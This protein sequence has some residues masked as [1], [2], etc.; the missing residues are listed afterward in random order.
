MKKLTTKTL[1]FIVISALLASLFCVFAYADEL[2]E[3]LPIIGVTVSSGTGVYTETLNLTDAD[4]DGALTI[5]DALILFHDAAYEGG[6]AAG[7]G[8]AV[9]Q[10]GLG[11]TK[12][13]GI[14]NG[15][16][17]GYYVNDAAAFNLSD[18]TRILAVP[19]EALEGI[20]G[21]ATELWISRETALPLSAAL[22]PHDAAVW[23]VER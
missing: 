5:N 19:P 14:E 2:D 6:A 23:R 17:Y 3:E 15:S 4:G 7:Y 22:L 16:S 21:K 20:S 18:E 9:S 12:L 11:I 10:Y 1:A 13:W 8:S